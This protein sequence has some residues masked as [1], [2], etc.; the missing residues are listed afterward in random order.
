MHKLYTN[1]G[2]HNRGESYPE[3]DFSE[4][5]GLNLSWISSAACVS[6][7]DIVRNLESQYNRD[8]KKKVGQ[9]FYYTLYR[10]ETENVCTTQT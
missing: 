6:N 3:H 7:D 1:V 5:D 9:Y 4:L 10:E 8:P 2:Y